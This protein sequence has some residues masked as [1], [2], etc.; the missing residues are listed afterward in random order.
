MTRSSP[1]RVSRRRF[2]ASTATVTAAGVAGCSD[3]TSEQPAD[4]PTDPT[5]SQPTD[6]QRGVETVVDI[7]GERVPEN[8][9]FGPDGALYFGITA[10]ELR[11]L[12]PEQAA[13]SGLALADVEQVATLPGAVGVEASPDGIIYV[14]VAA[15]D[16]DSGV[17]SVSP[18]DRTG[19]LAAISGFPND[20]LYD[21]DHDRLLV[22]ESQ[23]GAVY[24][25]TS[26]GSRETW[27]DDER[28]ST[29]S[30]GANG[31]TRDSD[32][33]VYVAVTRAPGETGRL[34]RVPVQNDGTAGDAVM[35]FEGSDIYGADGIA[36]MDG[37]IY[38]AVNGQNRVLRVTPEGTPTVV[39]TGDDGLLFP[40]DVAFDGED[41]SA[42]LFICNFAN[43]SPD[44]GA[45]L[46]TDVLVD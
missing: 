6:A 30:F 40:S 4:S 12:T 24:S 44:D 45:I 32:G 21:T 33:D 23:G 26:D 18:G 37:A 10:G 36:A 2:L 11:R 1:P 39:A 14:A 13:S 27:L 46:R 29:D 16:D 19:Q 43:Q 17:W 42:S 35:F 20:I 9:A 5:P 22:T 28:L 7:P 25:V 15:Q 38:V 41:L 31:I 3:R 8:L 34:L